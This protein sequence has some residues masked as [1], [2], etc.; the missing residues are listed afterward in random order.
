[1]YIDY[2]SL[3]LITSKKPIILPSNKF[4]V[5]LCCLR[6][7]LFTGRKTKK[8]CHDYSLSN[9]NLLYAC[10]LF[11]GLLELLFHFPM[12]AN[13]FSRTMLLSRV[14]FRSD[15]IKATINVDNY[16]TYYQCILT[17]Q[18]QKCIFSP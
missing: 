1:V 14:G 4:C 13:Y 15:R 16:S 6:S 17:D 18:N 12:Q 9:L 11:C 5:A 2:V 10:N 3:H 7:H 8:L